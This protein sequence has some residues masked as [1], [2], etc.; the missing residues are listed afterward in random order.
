MTTPTVVRTTET[1]KRYQM[2]VA[3]SRYSEGYSL[4]RLD[5]QTGRVHLFLDGGPTQGI[6]LL[7]VRELTEEEVPAFWNQAIT[8]RRNLSSLKGSSNET[9]LTAGPLDADL[10]APDEDLGTEETGDVVSITAEVAAPDPGDGEKEQ[11]DSTPEETPETDSSGDGEASAETPETPVAESVSPTPDE[12]T[13]TEETTT[14]I[15]SP[16]LATI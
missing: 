8:Y 2:V 4:M 16:E 1:N 13:E 10:L 11:G 7:P 14:E 12:T 6:A 15:E 5:S 9:A 3:Q